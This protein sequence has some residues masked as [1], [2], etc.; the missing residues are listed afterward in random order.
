MSFRLASLLT[1]RLGPSSTISFL[2]SLSTA[3]RETFE[4]DHLRSHLRH[5]F[6]SLVSREASPA[7]SGGLFRAPVPSLGS[8]IFALPPCTQAIDLI[9]LFFDDTGRLFP[10]IHKASVL[11]TYDTAIQSGLKN[12]R[13]SFLALLNAMFAI[14]TYMHDYDHITA[15]SEAS[16]RRAETFFVRAK[17]LI[18]DMSLGSYC[19]ETGTLI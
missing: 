9:R 7:P 3:A 4:Y 6:D 2:R 16:A 19:L 14:A 13:A 12:V 17:A 1:R 11:Q 15:G 18:T 10:F 8:S 5:G